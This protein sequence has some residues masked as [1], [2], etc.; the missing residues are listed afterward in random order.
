M[1]VGGCGTCVVVVSVVGG[2]ASRV[3]GGCDALNKDAQWS[4]QC[5]SWTM[6]WLGGKVHDDKAMEVRCCTSWSFGEAGI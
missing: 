1:R 5:G 4:S 6:W 2:G 3:G